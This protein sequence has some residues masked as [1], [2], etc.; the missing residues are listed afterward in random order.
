MSGRGS[1]I[2][3]SAIWGS[4]RRFGRRLAERR[5]ATAVVFALTIMPVLGFVALAFDVGS[6]VWARS[7]LD[8]AAD[9]AA[10]SAVM[11]GAQDYAADPSTTFKP[12]QQAGIKRFN[13]QAMLMPGVTVASLGVGVTRTG[14]TI[15]ATVTYTANYKTAFAQLF[16]F[17]TLPAAGAASTSRT[18]S[19]YFDI[20]ILMDNSSSMTIAASKTDMARLGAL[21]YQYDRNVAQNQDCAFGCHYNAQS[22]DFYGVAKSNGIALRIDVLSQAVQGVIDTISQ[23]PAASQFQVELYAFNS[24]VSTVQSP[25]SNFAQAKQAARGVTL[26]VTP[27]GGSADTNVPL[28]LQQMAKTLPAAGDGSSQATPL[29]YLFIVTDGVADYFDTKRNRVLQAFNPAQCAAL[30][31]KGV[32]IMTLYTQYYP[33]VPPNVPTANAY[34]VANVA[35]FLNQIFPNLQACAS[36]PAY[37]FQAT[38]AASINAALQ[39]MVQAAISVPA[40]FT[41]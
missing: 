9:A 16:G 30:K 2:W 18:N 32:Q 4:V 19:P 17:P 31:A 37:A 34:Y 14:G 38:D 21:T 36:S 1:A 26:P 7:E 8:L 13:A 40:R 10:L 27:D 11:R 33:I 41:Q 25:T 5:A 22:N 39:A 29:R 28:A 6:V 24:S 15:K 3:G 35:P 20:A 12:A 23:S